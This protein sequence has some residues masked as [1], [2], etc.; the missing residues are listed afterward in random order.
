[1]RNIQYKLLSPTPIP[2]I[3]LI[4]PQNLNVSVKKTFSLHSVGKMHISTSDNWRV[5]GN[6]KIYSLKYF[7][8]EDK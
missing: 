5:V 1:M 2:Q 4:A 6:D 7:F 8:L 3:L